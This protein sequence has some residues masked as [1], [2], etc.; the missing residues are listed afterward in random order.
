MSLDAAYAMVALLQAKPRTVAELASI[1]EVREKAVRRH[2]EVMEAQHLITF[3][4]FRETGARG[5]RPT[6]YRW[7]K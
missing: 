6:V 7:C 1:A 5:H 4:G 2:I 3:D